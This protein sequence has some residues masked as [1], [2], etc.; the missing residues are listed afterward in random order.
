MHGGKI[1]V[2]TW[3]NIE[4]MTFFQ[5]LCHTWFKVK[6]FIG[7]PIWYAEERLHCCTDARMHGCMVALMHGYTVAP[8]HLCTVARLH[9]CTVTQLHRCTVAPLHG[10]TV[11]RLHGC[12]VAPLPVEAWATGI[13]MECNQCF[14]WALLT[15]EQREPVWWL[16]NGFI[17][18]EFDLQPHLQIL[19]SMAL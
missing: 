5:C 10:C 4:L 8:L 11:A 7:S 18:I 14:F 13:E 3:L 6:M 2:I 1:R 19:W 15:N 12:T 9:L 17:W 16:R